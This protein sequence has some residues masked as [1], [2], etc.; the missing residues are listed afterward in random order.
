MQKDVLKSTSAEVREFFTGGFGVHHAGMLRPD[1]TLSER[2][3]SDGLINVLVCTATL[4]WGVNLPYRR[5]DPNPGLA[6]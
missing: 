2:L 4:A 1:R 6:L 3:F 5:E